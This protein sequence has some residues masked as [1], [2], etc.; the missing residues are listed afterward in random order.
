L[1][2]LLQDLKYGLRML[3]KDPGFTAVAVITLALGIG[4]NT[5]IFSLV[6]AFL[7]RRLPVK[8]PEQLVFVNRVS[9][10]GG[11]EDDF[12]YP[13]FEQFRDHNQSFSG[14]FAWDDS[15]V[16]VTVD[17]QTAM[18]PGD[19]VSGTYFDVLGVGAMLGRTFTSDDD[20][21]GGKPVAVISYSYWQ[22]QF[23]GNPAAIGKTIYL[24]RIPFA[25]IGVTPPRFFGRN[26]AGRSADVVLPMFVHPQL[27]L[28]DHSTFEIMARLKPGVTPQ[29]ARADLDVIYHQAQTQ[30]AGSRITP[31]VEHE[32]HAQ[33]IELKPGLRGTSGLREEFGTELNIL[34]AVVGIALL[35]ASVNVASLLLARAASRQKETAI[36]LAI[37]ASRGRLVRQ[38]LTESVLLSVLGGALGL[39]FAEWGTGFLLTVLSYGRTAVSFELEP[40][41]RIL[42]FTFGVSLLT[43]ILCGLAPAL[44]ATRVD[45]NPVLK[46][47]GSRE[48]HPLRH[49]LAKSLV[50]SQVTLSLV[51]L[52]AAGLLIRSLGQ[53]Y[54]VDTGFD[55]DKVLVGWVIP[56]LAGYDHAKEMRLYEELMEKLNAIPGVRSASLS[57]YRL[58]FARPDRNLWVQG[59]AP[60]VDAD[61][62]VYCYP[63]G[64]RFF[65]TQGIGLLLGRA[66]SSADAETAPK[67]AV[68]SESVARQ[69]FPDKDPIGRRLG[70]GKPEASGDFQIVGVARDIQPHLREQ[71]PLRAVYIPYT[72]AFPDDYGQMTFVIRTALDPSGIAPAVRHQVQLIDRNLPLGDVSTQAAD[73]D[74]KLGD[75]RALATLLSLFAALGLVLASIGLYGTISYGVA[76]RTNEVGIRMALGARQGDML[77]MVLREALLLVA[78]GVAIGVPLSIAGARLISTL[79]FGVKP[80][81]AVAICFSSGVMMAIA[82][83]AAYLPARRATKVDPMVALRYE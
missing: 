70:F 46:G 36:R 10:K 33:R 16:A 43:G 63:V 21:P 42:G 45:L 78:I 7:L 8:S 15:N 35:I 80:A 38:L 68:I 56:V 25:V 5:A 34:M 14:L 41:V 77:R 17:G 61:R 13:A 30:A 51:L 66:F 6:D 12:P 40:D 23:A 29:Q 53:L 24:G 44:R 52:I 37:G 3:V 4:A 67:V 49:G 82:S 59:S 50:V 58:L 9:P 76:K 75:E 18:V 69:F 71:Q 55:R 81:D 73:V 26:V 74:E 20:Q 32:I 47:T 48:S 2:T 31:Q 65:E 54:Q 27:A 64:P 62:E 83:L 28:K 11:T 60:V 79:I 19:F 39:L 72:Q 57:R 1:R 22:R